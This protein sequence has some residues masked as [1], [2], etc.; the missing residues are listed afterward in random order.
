MNGEW[1]V[2]KRDSEYIIVL[3]TGGDPLYGYGSWD[4][5]SG[6]FDSWE[7]AE[8]SAPVEE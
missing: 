4:L 3:C 2:L 7:D 8:I 6:P 5:F 1:Y